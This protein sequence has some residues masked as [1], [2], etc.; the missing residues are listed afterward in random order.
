M[1]EQN[2]FM[3]LEMAHRGYVLENGAVV[4]EDQADLIMRMPRVREAYLG[5]ENRG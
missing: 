5:E 3:A 4:L 2:A 1:V